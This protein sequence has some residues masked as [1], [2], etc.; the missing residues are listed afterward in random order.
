MFVDIHTHILPFVDD[1]SESWETSIQ[2]IQQAEKQ[3]VV[4]MI[5][6][7]HILSENDYRIEDDIISKYQELKKRMKESNLKIKL[8]LGSEIYA[9]PDMTLNHKISTY[10]NNKKYFLVEFPMTSIPRFVADKFFEFIVSEK[11]P[12]IAHPERNLGFQNKTRLAYDFVQR[13]ALM[14]INS[15]S[16]LGKHGS[17]AKQIAFKLISH[18]LAHFVA[19]DCHDPEH[20]TVNLAQAYDVVVKN[21]DKTT[22][23]LLFYHNPNKILKAEKIEPLEPIPIDDELKQPFWK[24]INF[25]NKK[26]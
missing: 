4:T 24:R 20:R 2:M 12:I 21:W 26:Y 16:I 18:H 8:Y 13:G 17:A 22:A 15:L 1:G 23:D 3:G 7:P 9:Q 19:S 14:Q 5:A 11:I 25:F 6:T 10:N